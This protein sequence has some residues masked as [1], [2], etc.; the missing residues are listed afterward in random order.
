MSAACPELTNNDPAAPHNVMAESQAWQV[1]EV[2]YAIN[3]LPEAVQVEFARLFGIELR[4]AAPATTTLTF[5]V[6]A[7]AGVYVT[8]PAGTRVAT[9]DGSQVFAT[10]ADL[11]I[12]PGVPAGDA[13][14]TAVAAGRLVLA[15]GTLT[16]TIDP[17]AWVT[18]V[19]NAN[20]VDS[21]AD[22]ESVLSALARARNYQQRA[23][24]IVSA[25]DLKTAISDEVMLGNCLMKVFEKTE[26][27]FWD[28]D[29]ELGRRL[30]NTTV[31][32]MTAAGNP[33]S[34]E[35]RQ[36]IN[37]LCEQLVGHL[38]VFIKDPV[39]HI[40]NVAADV[41]LVNLSR[42]AEAL[43]RIT[44]SLTSFY[45]V[46]EANFGRPVLRSEIIE[47]IEGTP[48]VDYIVPQAGGAILAQPAA[49]ID[50]LPFE[51][52]QLVTVT[53]NFV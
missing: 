10:D 47:L 6:A 29:T 32:L 13:A 44:D 51:L 40:F 33:V 16:R 18:A 7:P 26:D 23:E 39:F 49:D 50:L 14:A 4:L 36:Q 1:E 8:V 24:R 38:N 43:Q 48:L 45:A 35:V 25:N 3:R 46:K 20:V 15:A 41:R 42:Q 5:A 30:G 9:A 21:G 17:V 53:I 52:P 28:A 22:Q 27:G 37:A 11:E 34:T 19:T 12:A 31:V 2:L